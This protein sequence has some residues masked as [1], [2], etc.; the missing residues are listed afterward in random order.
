MTAYARVLVGAHDHGGGVPADECPD[1][2]FDVLIA[3]NER[4]GI[5]RDGVDVRRL[6]ERGQAEV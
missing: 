2:A 5:W 3:G 6:G 4:L 1:T